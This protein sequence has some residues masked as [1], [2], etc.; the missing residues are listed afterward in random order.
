MPEPLSVEQLR[1]QLKKLGYLSHGIERWFALD[2]WRSRTFWSELLVIASKVGAA[3]SLALTIP[4]LSVMLLRNR[5]MEGVDL[6][7]LGL[8][9][10]A[11]SFAAVFVIVLL[12]ALFMRVR[13]RTPIEHPRVL[14]AI[15]IALSALLCAGPV[16]WWL[17][18]HS[19][20]LLLERLAFLSLLLLSFLFGVTILAAALLSF[21]IHSTQQI[22]S[23]RHRRR[24]LPIAVVAVAIFISVWLLS[25]HSEI[26]SP[27][28]PQQIVIRPTGLRI[29]FLAVDGLSYEIFAAGKMASG[30]HILPCTPVAAP[31]AAERWATAGSGTE[32]R[33]HAVRA[34]EGVRSRL[35]GS[36]LQSVSTTDVLLRNVVPAFG[37]FRRAPIPPTVRRRDYVWEILASRGVSSFAVNWWVTDQKKSASLNSENQE[38]VFASAH[39]AG[40]PP[41]EEAAAIDR[42]ALSRVAEAATKERRQF[43]TA[44]LPALDI[45]LNRIGLDASARLTF[46]VGQ[47]EAIDQAVSDLHGQG[48]EVILLGM[49]GD[50]QSGRGVIGSTIP[51][52]SRPASALDV[53]PTLA[54]LQGFPASSEMK[55]SSLL[56]E[57]TQTRL[58]SFGAREQSSG[59]QHVDEEYYQSLKSLGYV[60]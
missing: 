15:S 9:Y 18:F 30:L 52:T 6:V 40:R 29:A 49:P 45:I 21:S 8:S 35:T 39:Q 13:P 59:S 27:A 51:L 56:P 17:G 58:P 14:L 42:I 20:A 54:D 32:G 24:M 46:S 43:V 26:Q 31:S 34:I 36:V 19:P 48:Y 47:L 50:N 53:A 3:M 44:F 55:G 12:A 10:M 7:A 2:P 16:A 57:S 28:R 1:D 5:P 11:F 23:V 4:I 33:L 41:A 37:F 38:H 60:Q 25:L 22:P